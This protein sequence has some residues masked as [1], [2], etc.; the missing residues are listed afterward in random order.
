MSV[1]SKRTCGDW[2][3][4]ERVWTWLSSQRDESARTRLY[5]ILA[6]QC[7]KRDRPYRGPH[8]VSMLSSVFMTTPARPIGR[9]SRPLRPRSSS[10]PS[11]SARR[12]SASSASFERRPHVSRIAGVGQRQNM[13]YGDMIFIYTVKNSLHMSIASV[14]TTRR[15]SILCESRFARKGR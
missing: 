11:R 13:S 9:P 3:R 8:E 6:E 5:R 15:T 12:A 7:A 4:R 10:S 14:Q 1:R 2:P